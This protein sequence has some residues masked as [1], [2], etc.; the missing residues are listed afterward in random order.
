MGG[1]TERMGTFDTAFKLGQD[2]LKTASIC[3]NKQ[4]FLQVF[5]GSG[6]GKIEDN[7][8]SDDPLSYTTK[9]VMDIFP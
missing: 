9:M 4:D 2:V 8:T 3:L 7:L 1:M 6:I 5:Q